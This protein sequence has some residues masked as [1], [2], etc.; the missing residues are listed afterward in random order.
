MKL[1]SRS[2]NCNICFRFT[3]ALSNRYTSNNNHLNSLPLCEAV[4]CTPGSKLLFCFP[5]LVD[6]MLG[7]MAHVLTCQPRLLQLGAPTSLFGNCSLRVH[8]KSKFRP[9][10]FFA[11]G[12][13]RYLVI[14]TRF[15]LD[16]I[17]IYNYR[18]NHKLY[19]YETLH[20]HLCAY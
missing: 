6:R 5:Q 3:V 14:L 16:L 18:S 4:L 8:V 17:N 10:Q 15:Y 9:R 11:T 12:N 13:S 1:N 2:Y 20:S 19:V 7:V